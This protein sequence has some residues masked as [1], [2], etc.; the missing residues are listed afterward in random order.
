MVQSKGSESSHWHI[1]RRAGL[2]GSFIP[3][4]RCLTIH[5]GQTQPCR[6]R[7]RAAGSPLIA[8]VAGEAL[9]RLG[10]ARTPPFKRPGLGTAYPLLGSHP[11]LTRFGMGF[12]ALNRTDLAS[13]WAPCSCWANSAV[14]AATFLL[15]LCERG[16]RAADL[17]DEVRER[18]CCPLQSPC[19]VAT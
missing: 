17:R 8:V 4:L 14:N 9:T 6:E 15:G 12:T 19:P 18:R 10:R 7:A 5:S 16:R 1:H 2:E 13:S 3:Q 11:E